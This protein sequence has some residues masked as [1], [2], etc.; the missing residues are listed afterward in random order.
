MF[1][2]EQGEQTWKGFLIIVLRLYWK[3]LMIHA[4]EMFDGWHTEHI[5]L[6]P[7]YLKLWIQDND[8]IFTKKYPHLSYDLVAYTSGYEHTPS[9]ESLC[10][11][12]LAHGL[13]E[14]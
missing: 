6:P 2:G 14:Y 9:R 10:K 3:C 11:I 1:W 7:K 5:Q 12:I 8:Y 4:D 13:V